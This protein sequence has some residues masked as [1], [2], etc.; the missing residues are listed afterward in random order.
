MF[1]SLFLLLTSVGLLSAAPSHSNSL[2]QMTVDGGRIIGGVEISIE[3]APWQVSLELNGYNWC[4]GVIYSKNI[5]ITAAHCAYDKLPND[6]SVRAGATTHNLGGSV[7]GV[8]AIS[9]H[10][11]Y[12][13]IIATNDIALL[14]LSSPLRLSKFVQ[15]IPLATEE[16]SIGS[17]ASVSGWGYTNGPTSNRLRSVNVDIVARAECLKVYGEKVFIRTSICASA[18]GKDACVGD[19]GGPLVYQ[20][21]LVGIVS[22]GKGC[23]LSTYPGVYANVPTLNKW[24][25]RTASVLHQ[26]EEM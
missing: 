15:V 11:Q 5:I 8:S 25:L 3:K 22:H 10:E 1:D 26:D 7:V 14:L 6:L 23:A 16:P 4:G 18:P 13:N 9:L 2:G 21:Q 17:T 19:S 20:G 24:I 12:D